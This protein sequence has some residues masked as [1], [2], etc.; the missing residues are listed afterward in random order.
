[1]ESISQGQVGK[2]PSGSHLKALHSFRQLPVLL[3]R[4]CIFIQDVEQHRHVCSAFLLW[5]SSKAPVLII[6][7]PYKSTGAS[8]LLPPSPVYTWLM[9]MNWPQSMQRQKNWRGIHS[10][11]IFSQ[12]ISIFICHPSAYVPRSLGQC[13]EQGQPDFPLSGHFLQLFWEDPISHQLSIC[14]S[15]LFWYRLLV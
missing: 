12:I 9:V 15:L 3:I 10:P 11:V 2:D 1:M 5:H 6:R 7:Q 4:R 8:K 14:L 13:S